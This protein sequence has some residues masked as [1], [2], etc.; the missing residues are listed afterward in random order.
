VLLLVCVA[1]AVGIVAGDGLGIGLGV[2]LSLAIGHAALALLAARRRALVGVSILGLGLGLGVAAQAARPRPPPG[3]ITGGRAQLDGW[4]ERPVERAF[5]VARLTI[6]L[7]A[8]AQGG[9]ER[10]AAGRVLLSVKGDPVEPLLPGDYLRVP[11][12]LRT[13]R[14]FF[15]PGAPD[16]ARRVATD[17]AIAVGSVHEPAA[18][19]RL[20]EV[21]RRV[22]P[23]RAIEALRGRMAATLH[24][25]DGDD[26]A[27]VASLVLGDRGDVGRPLDDAFRAAGVSHVLSVSG[28]HLA[29]AAWLFYA[30]L[31]FIL[32]RLPGLGGGRAV[33]RWAALAAL[34]ATIA[35]TLLTGAEVATVRACVVAA[36]FFV[37][38]ALERRVTAIGALTLAAI[39]VLADAPLELFD[40]SFQL[41]FAAALGTALLTRRFTPL[42]LRTARPGVGWHALRFIAQLFAASLAALVATAPIAAWHFAQF[43]PA[44]LV[45]NLVVVPL[46]ELALVPGGLVACT[47]STLHLPGA[48][49]LIQIAGFLAHTLAA[50]VRAAAAFAPAWNVGAP[51]MVELVAWY[52]GLG[53]VALGIRRAGRIALAGVLVVALS[54]GTRELVRRTTTTLTAHFLDVGQ[55]DACV[56]ELPGGHVV[57]IDGGGSFDPD[58]DP[59]RQVIAPFLH[60]TGIRRID[61]IVLSHPHPDHANGLAALVDELPVGEV[62]TNAPDSA[63]PG[64]ARLVAVARA[65]GVPVGAP[66]PLVLG[67]ALLRP[68]AGTVTDAA[69]GENDNSIVLAIEHAGRRLIFAGDLERAGEAALVG[70]GVPRADVVKVPHHG[71]KTSSTSDFVAALHPSLAVISVGEDNRWRFPDPG[72]VARW[73]A[74]GAR[75][76]R[77]D[78]DGTIDVTVSGSGALGV[79]CVRCSGS[80]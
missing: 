2:G 79:S 28:L 41:S 72:V 70:A 56:L 65:H 77:T 15:V 51:S 1:Y 43:A 47:A 66:R 63:Q 40:P 45:A 6:D 20:L 52:V 7:T 55:G 24:V 18:L 32:L 71:S 34:P 54:L 74:A 31:G 22:S 25:L 11:A 19:A 69:F 59:G 53:A 80:R 27:L 21:P 36:V 23:W 37:G 5:G 78:R 17:G 4:L 60:R 46:A 16:L 62:W 8:V 64:T 75:V 13:P 30:G 42:P 9:V 3:L 68:L 44:G 10:A 35:Y 73:E 39:L 26:R 12:R 14:G 67:S 57:I 29:V 58:F 76:L 38:I 33:R 49:L 61:L 50:F 48:V